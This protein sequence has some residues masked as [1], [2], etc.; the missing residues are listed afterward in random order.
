MENSA[1]LASRLHIISHHAPHLRHTTVV[2]LRAGFVDGD[3][4]G[5]GDV[6]VVSVQGYGVILLLLVHFI[7]IYIGASKKI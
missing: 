7:S 3:G 6:A 2:G 5:E 4:V 1:A